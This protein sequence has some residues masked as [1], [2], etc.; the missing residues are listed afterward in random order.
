[1]LI[2]PSFITVY[3]HLDFLPCCY[4]EITVTSQGEI[5]PTSV[6]ASIQSTSDNPIL[7]NHLVANQVVEKGDLLI[8]YSETMEESQKTALETQLQRLEKQKEGLGILKQSLEKT[9]DLF[10]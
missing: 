1:M 5:A 8:K 4:K 10:F 6:I 3:F 7:A 2:I 9:T